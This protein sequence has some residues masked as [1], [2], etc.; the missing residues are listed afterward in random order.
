MIK[1][2]KQAYQTE[3]NIRKS[4]H[5]SMQVTGQTNSALKAIGDCEVKF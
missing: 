4:I 1:V 5:T 2:T 3:P